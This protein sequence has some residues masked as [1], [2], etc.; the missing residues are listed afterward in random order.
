MPPERV[1]LRAGA[2]P[3]QFDRLTLPVDLRGVDR[4]PQ[5]QGH[6]LAVSVRSDKAVC[7]RYLLLQ[8]APRRRLCGLLD[9]TLVPVEEPLKTLPL[10]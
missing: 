4:R 10:K 7:L 8:V 9:H 2:G 5:R 6:G 1:D 3:D